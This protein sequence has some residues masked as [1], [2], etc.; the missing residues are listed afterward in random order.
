[1]DWLN[2]TPDYSSLASL[3][4]WI[5]VLE[6]CAAVLLVL[7]GLTLLIGW[8][9]HLSLWVRLSAL[10]PLAASIG[11]AIAVHALHTS[12]VYWD[13]SLTDLVTYARGAPLTF[14]RALYFIGTATHTA[15]VVGWISI[16]VTAVLLV[17]GLIGVWHLRGKAV[18]DNKWLPSFGSLL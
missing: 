6:I 3:L 11:A 15:M 1:M 12:Y 17:L 16:I 5:K 4:L 7:A 18:P 8:V 2:E 10:L 14:Y 9:R 13:N